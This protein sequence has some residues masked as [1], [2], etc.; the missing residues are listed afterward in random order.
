MPT[1]T[2]EAD[3]VISALRSDDQAAFAELTERFRRLL[4][5]H[6]YRMLGSFDEAEEIV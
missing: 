6:C 5:V 1:P 2:V 3:E 4:H